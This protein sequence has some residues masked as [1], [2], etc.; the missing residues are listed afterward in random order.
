MDP[1][2]CLLFSPAMST[3]CLHGQCIKTTT[4]TLILKPSIMSRQVKSLF[5]MAK[6][7]MKVGFFFHNNVTNGLP[8]I[9]HPPSS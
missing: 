6:S 5:Q 1:A 9:Q 4:Y 7:L 3:L 8:E 2:A